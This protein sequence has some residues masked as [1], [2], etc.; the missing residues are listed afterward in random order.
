MKGKTL[1]IVIALM[2]LSIGAITG[3]ER[4]FLSEVR[5]SSTLNGVPVWVS[6]AQVGS[7]SIIEKM[8]ARDLRNNWAEHEGRLVRFTGVVE[9]NSSPIFIGPD[10]DRILTLEGAPAIEVYPLKTSHL[11][12]IYHEGDEYEFTGFLIRHE[13]HAEHQKSGNAKMCVYAFEIRHLGEAQ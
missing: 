3:A 10:S 8:R 1:C 9:N 11:P 13:A 7:A 4:I 2:V 6:V 5:F 12:A